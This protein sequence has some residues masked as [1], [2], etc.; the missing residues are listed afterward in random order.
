MSNNQKTSGGFS[1]L[2]AAIAI[3]IALAIGVVI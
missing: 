2:M 3:V 1:S